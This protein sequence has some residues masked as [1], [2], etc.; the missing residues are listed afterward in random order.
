MTIQEV[1]GG[2]EFRINALKKAI[3]V[4][5]EKESFGRSNLEARLE[6]LELIHNW[7]RSNKDE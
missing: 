4:L 7:I 1:M 5:E 2:L 6:E 3:E